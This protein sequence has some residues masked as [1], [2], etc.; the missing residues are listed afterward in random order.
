[1][2][3]AKEGRRMSRAH[4]NLPEDIHGM[5]AAEGILTS[6]G[7]MTST[8]PWSPGA[9]ANPAWWD[10]RR[11]NINYGNG[12][13]EVNGRTIREGDFISIDGTTGEVIEGQLPASLGNHPGA[14]RGKDPASG[15]SDLPA[16]RQA[17]G[18]GG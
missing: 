4:R 1:M 2:E 15:F 10:V 8:P 13:M 9:W 3:L 6:R 12:A 11:W 5:N 17:H 7:G 14:H 16:V 18:L